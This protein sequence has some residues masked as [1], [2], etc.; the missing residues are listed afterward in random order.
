[1]ADHQDPVAR[2]DAE[3]GQEPDQRAE[4][5]D[6]RRRASRPARRRPAPS[7]AAGTSAPPAAGCRRRPA[8]A[9]RSRSPRRC[10]TCSAGPE[11]RSARSTRPAPRRGTRRG[12]STSSRRSSTSS[13]AEARSRPS[14]FAPTS[15]RRDCCVALDRGSA[16]ARCGRRPP[17]SRRTRPPP[18]VSIG[19]RFDVGHAVARRRDAPDV[20]VVGLAA[21]EDV[22]DLLAGEQRRR[23]AAD[24]ARLEAVAAAPCRGPARP[25]SCG[26]SSAKSGLR[27]DHAVDVRRSAPRSRPPSRAARA[28]RG[29]R[30][31][32]RPTRSSRSAPP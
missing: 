5:Q 20:H 23:L 32:R 27:V 6:R 24:V 25:R 21:V 1:M 30:S 16:S 19:S 7:A 3:H 2:G 17:R 11:R 15:I 22:A 9:G 8:A 31:A 13:T 18:G 26:S 10:R 14:T 28:A 12:M 29:R 4:R